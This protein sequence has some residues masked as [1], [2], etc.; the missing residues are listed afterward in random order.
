MIRGNLRILAV[1]LLAAAA[2]VPT[3]QACMQATNSSSPPASSVGAANGATTDTTSQD[4]MPKRIS[5]YT[6]SPDL[7]RKARNRGR[8]QFASHV[9][10]FLYGLLVLWLILHYKLGAK[11]RDWAECLSRKRFLQAVTFVP[12]L[13]L[14]IGVFQLPVH[15]F[16]EWVLKL[17]RISVQSWPSWGGDWAKNQALICVI[18]SVLVW[19]LYAVMHKTPRRWWF[20]FWIVS[21]PITL[22]VVF[23]SPIVIDP[24][25]SKFEPLAKEAP[26]LVPRL[27]SVARRAGQDIPPERMFWMLASDKTIETNASVEGL[28]ASKRIV[29]WDTTL[30]QETADGILMIFGHELGH[31]VLGHNWKGFLFYEVMA[32]VLL[33]LGYRSI[34]WMLAHWGHH[35]SVR[36]LDD[37]A[38]LP[39]L[40]LLMSL[41]GF[42]ATAISNT[43]I[44][45]QENQADIY[46]LE[47]THSIVS[48]PGQTSAY[49]F[50][51]FG[52]SVLMDPAPNPVNVFLFYQHPPVPDRIHL[53][54]NYD[55]WSSGTSPQFVK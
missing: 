40:L 42:V 43:Y 32:L 22:F 31:Y 35:W 24:L 28:G 2:F 50:Q 11:Y 14:T 38:S 52:E 26:Q 33:F 30:A 41:F 10:A 18:G 9:F 13:A 48:N 17:Y 45:H 47:V 23:I 25:F 34:G 7:F 51:K 20:Y 19:I 36:G 21:L 8:I 12:L 54:V 3:V 27:Q 39:A 44:R 5:A 29:V 55:P 53:F 49:S 16:D 46:S 1:G 15:I 37:W 6:L 4:E